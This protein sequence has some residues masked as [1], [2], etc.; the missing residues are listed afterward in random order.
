MRYLALFASGTAFALVTAHAFP[1]AKPNFAGRWVMAS[2]AQPGTPAVAGAAEFCGG[3]LSGSFGPFSN[4]LSWGTTILQDNRT[5]TITGKT[6]TGELKRLYNLDGSPSTNLMV[7][8]ADSIRQTATARWDGSKLVIATSYTFSGIAVAR[9]MALSLDNGVL[10]VDMSGTGG[11]AGLSDMPAVRSTY[12]KCEAQAAELTVPA[13]N[14]AATQSA[15]LPS[16][17]SLGNNVDSTSGIAST[18]TLSQPVSV[19]SLVIVMVA[20]RQATPISVTDSK[21]NAWTSAVQAVNSTQACAAGIFYSI[22]ATTL[23]PGDRVT[24]RWTLNPADSGRVARGVSPMTSSR[25][26]GAIK[27]TNVRALDQTGTAQNSS[28]DTVAVTTS[29]SVTAS[30]ELLVGV[31]CTG[32]NVATTFSNT[33]N[34]T[35]AFEYSTEFASGSFNYRVASGLT[36]VQAFMATAAPFAAANFAT[37]IA[38]F[39]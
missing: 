24:A 26:L 36:G 8:G 37:V 16:V 20:G 7:V 28:T 18:L 39:K 5:F 12:K 13:R 34:F 21:G 25:A 17:T 29:S 14:S 3:G 38:T 6:S 33:N 19:G 15:T 23:A 22:L 10:I 27:A 32:K 35:R 1:Q 2:G 30:S 4:G 9:T 31:T 11:R